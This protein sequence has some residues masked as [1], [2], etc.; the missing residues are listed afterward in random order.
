M[1]HVF[2]GEQ[3]FKQTAVSYRAKELHLRSYQEPNYL[4]EPSTDMRFLTG[5]QETLFF[6][7]L[8]GR[9]TQFCIHSFHAHRSCFVERPC[10]N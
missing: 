6:I 7:F 10:G 3:A 1:G 9:G 4:K 5:K 2:Q 8:R